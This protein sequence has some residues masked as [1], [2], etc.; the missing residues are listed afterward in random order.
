MPL[1]ERNVVYFNALNN[2]REA[3]DSQEV[4]ALICLGSPC[5][6]MQAQYKFPCAFGLSKAFG[7]ANDDVMVYNAMLCDEDEVAFREHGWKSIES[8]FDFDCRSGDE[9]L[10]IFMPSNDIYC[11]QSV[12]DYVQMNRALHRTV[13]FG[14]KLPAGDTLDAM[15][16]E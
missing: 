3:V 13:L 5:R 1:M 14:D 8:K 4:D 15:R 12:L 9:V 6:N 7:V 11:V 10:L 16:L 2:L